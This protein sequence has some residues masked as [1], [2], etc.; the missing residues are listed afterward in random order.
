MI[1]DVQVVCLEQGKRCLEQDTKI[2]KEGLGSCFEQGK[3]TKGR[4]LER[5]T[6]NLEIS[7]ATDQALIRAHLALV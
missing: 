4:Y 3:R 6:I 5:G 7:G 1:N 2:H